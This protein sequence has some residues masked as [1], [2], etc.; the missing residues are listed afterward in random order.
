LPLRLYYNQP[1]YRTSD[2]R[3]GSHEIHQVGIELIGASGVRADVEVLQLALNSL[4]ACLKDF[5]FELGYSGIFKALVAGLPIDDSKREILRECIELKNYAALSDELD[6]IGNTPEVNAL[7]QLP[8]LFGGK[9]VLEQAAR[10]IDDPVIHEQLD[11]LEHLYSVLA[12]LGFEDKL[13]IDLGLVNQNDYYTGIVFSAYAHGSGEKVLSGGRYDALLANFGYDVCACGFGINIG[14]LVQ[15]MPAVETVSRKASV[16]VF[17]D[18]GC[19]AS[20]FYYISKLAAEGV[21]A[22][23]CVANNQYEAVEYAKAC[24]FDSLIK[25]AKNCQPEELL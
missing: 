25:I 5:R 1:C 11:Y 15:A 6:T 23:F 19:E 24:G 16:L 2:I 21:I 13:M 17:A 14:S 20:A 8:R 9:N 22:E 7:K 18:D 10:L 12:E 4:S 3:G